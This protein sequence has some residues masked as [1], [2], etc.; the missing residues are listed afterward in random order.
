M[1]QER[2]EGPFPAEAGAAA[3][4]HKRNADK[5]RN[6]FGTFAGNIDEEGSTF[7]GDRGSAARFFYCAKAARSERGEDNDH[8]TVKPQKLMRW[9]C[10]L[11]TPAGGTVVD[12]FLGSGTTG[13]AALAEGFRFIGI[14]LNPEYVAIAERRLG[15]DLA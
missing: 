13:L 3:P 6:T 15:L 11:V 10:R 14:E 2:S 1:A 4:V 5:L 12:P 9:L 8:P 7:H